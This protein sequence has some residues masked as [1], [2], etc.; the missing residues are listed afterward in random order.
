[1]RLL[2]LLWGNYNKCVCWP[3]IV[4]ELQTLTVN[5]G[6]LR[7]WQNN[8]QTTVSVCQEALLATSPVISLLF[9]PSALSW[10]VPL[11]GFTCAPCHILSFF[12]F[13]FFY[14]FP[15]AWCLGDWGKV[16]VG[17]KQRAGLGQL[18]GAIGCTLNFF[19]WKSILF[20]LPLLGA[21]P[22]A[23]FKLGCVTS[24]GARCLLLTL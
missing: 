15:Q 21:V 6:W 7:Y 20:F 22:N 9:H 3:Y 5:N 11:Y 8:N 12:F 18:S 24:N 14:V 1:M 23:P 10:K 2:L 16:S 19:F 17:W 4:F 13:F